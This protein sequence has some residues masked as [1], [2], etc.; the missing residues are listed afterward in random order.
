[1][2]DMLDSN[3]PYGDDSLIVADYLARRLSRAKSEAFEAHSFG[4]ERCFAELQRATELRAAGHDRSSSEAHGRQPY[5]RSRRAIWQTLGV[6]A[7]IV[8]AVGVWF[9]LPQVDDTPTPSE[10]V[11]RDADDFP[12]GRTGLSLEV[13]RIEDGF[14]L[15][16]APVAGV[17]EYEV[18]VFTENGDPV[19][20]QRTRRTSIELTGA[21]WREAGSGNKFYGQVIALDELRQ[22]IMLSDFEPL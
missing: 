4:C 21:Q 7:T 20:E 14:S 8:L 17:D 9:A 1:M 18:R 16:W 3:C 22:T 12:G 13:G 19:F 11:Y 6:A 10:P 15:S 2:E 5:S